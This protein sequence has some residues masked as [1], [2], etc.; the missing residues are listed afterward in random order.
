MSFLSGFSGKGN[1]FD[2]Q[3]QEVGDSRHAPGGPFGAIILSPRV[4]GH[5]R[6]GELRKKDEK[7]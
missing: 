4:T 6:Q 1:S 5:R 7:F 2:G 3:S